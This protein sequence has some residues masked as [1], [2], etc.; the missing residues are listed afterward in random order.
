MTETRQGML[1]A[2]IEHCSVTSTNIIRQETKEDIQR[3]KRHMK[4]CSASLPIREMQIKTTMRYYLTP[5]RVA[6]INPETNVGEDA[7]KREP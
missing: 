4:R 2:V 6:N 7:E 5:V 3:A 1:V